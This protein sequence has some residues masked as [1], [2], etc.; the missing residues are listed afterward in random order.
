MELEYIMIS[1]ISETEKNTIPGRD[2]GLTTPSSASLFARC[3]LEVSTSV[4]SFLIR[5]AYGIRGPLYSYMT[6]SLLITSAAILFSNVT[7]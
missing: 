6:S 1:E 7:F 4:S 5:T 3:S 2:C